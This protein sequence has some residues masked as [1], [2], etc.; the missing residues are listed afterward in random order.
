MR[1]AHSPRISAALRWVSRPS[2]V[3]TASSVYLTK[4]YLRAAFQSQ[5]DGKGFSL[6]EILTM[7]PTDWFVSPDQGPAFLEKHLVPTFPLG[8]IK[9]LSSA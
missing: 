3:H 7:C 8:V 9:G 1:C 6:V 5:L 2:A 4:E